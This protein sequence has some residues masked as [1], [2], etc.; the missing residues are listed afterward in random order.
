M[1]Y[2]MSSRERCGRGCVRCESHRRKNKASGFVVLTTGR[3]KFVVIW[4]MTTRGFWENTAA[5]CRV[6]I[7]PEGGG[8]SF[9]RS[10]E[11]ID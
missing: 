8:R 1:T 10:L 9:F 3:L 7:F 6:D 5:I 11:Q 2:L 4:D